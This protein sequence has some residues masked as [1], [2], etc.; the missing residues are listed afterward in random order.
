MARCRTLV[1]I[2]QPHPSPSAPPSPLL[3]EGSRCS[4]FRLS[5][6]AISSHQQHRQIKISTVNWCLSAQRLFRRGELCSPVK[7]GAHPA[8][9]RTQF[10]PTGLCVS[11]SY[12]RTTDQSKFAY[13]SAK[14]HIIEKAVDVHGFYFG[15]NL[16]YPSIWIR[17][18]QGLP[19]S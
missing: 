17:S 7:Y 15:F 8:N 9:G 10:A 3:G 18:S 5:M 14:P 6:L 2:P 12:L 19:Q 4:P 13:G 11:F 16:Q 1:Q